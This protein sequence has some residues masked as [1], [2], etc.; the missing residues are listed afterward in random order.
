[1]AKGQKRSGREPK[2]PKKEKI[3]AL[4]WSSI[5]N[6]A[7]RRNPH[8]NSPRRSPHSQTPGERVAYRL[9]PHRGDPR[10]C[11]LHASRPS[12]RPA[13]QNGLSD[14]ILNPVDRNRRRVPRSPVS[15]PPQPLVAR[16]GRMVA[17]ARRLGGRH[18]RV[19]RVPSVGRRPLEGRSSRRA[20]P[21]SWHP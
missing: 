12:P 1:M 20:S 15:V 7:C 21:R 3:F 11:E 5:P 6:A 4:I 18:G 10:T 13:L 19:Q 9:H 17:L 8:A 2:K 16:A 14:V